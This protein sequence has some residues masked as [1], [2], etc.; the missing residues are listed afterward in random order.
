LSKANSHIYQVKDYGKEEQ[1]MKR[2]KR[3]TRA[4]KIEESKRKGIDKIV[5]ALQKI[6]K[7]PKHL[8]EELNREDNQ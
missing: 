4:Q 3:K 1:T 7:T 5:P 2:P 6:S 8:T